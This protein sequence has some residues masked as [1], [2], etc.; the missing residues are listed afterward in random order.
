[1]TTSVIGENR[2]GQSQGWNF[3]IAEK[4][5]ESKY[6]HFMDGECNQLQTDSTAPNW[7]PF[8]GLSSITPV[9]RIGES[10]EEEDQ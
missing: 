10:G 2:R 5:V 9:G 4:H 6:A 7:L 3:E 1:M 8:C